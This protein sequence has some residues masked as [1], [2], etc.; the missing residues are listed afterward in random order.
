MSYSDK[1][2]HCRDCDTDFTFSASEQEQF[3]VLGH[4]NDPKR[5]AACRAARKARRGD[6][7]AGAGYRN[8][9]REMFP[10][11]CASCG[12]AAQVPFE[13]RSGRPVYCSNCYRIRCQNCTIVNR[14]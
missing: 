7:G 13:P 6:N 2:L 9:R 12:Q 10:A 14:S 1:I 3:A 11:T 4:H 5:C 8:V